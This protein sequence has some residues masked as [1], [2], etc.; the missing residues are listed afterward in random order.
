MPLPSTIEPMREPEQIA[1]AKPANWV[2]HSALI[3]EHRRLLARVT[4][5]A[6][7][8]SVVIAFTIP[9]RYDSVARI[10]PPDPQGSGATLLAALLSHAGSAGGMGGLGGLLGGFLSSHSSSALFED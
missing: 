3:W 2:L 7:L 1:V 9:K 8:F 6:L 10:M 4:V 5:I